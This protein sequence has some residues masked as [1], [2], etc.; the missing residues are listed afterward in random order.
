MSNIFER[1]D[2]V[3]KEVA[4][5]DT[6]SNNE[7]PSKREILK[8]IDGYASYIGNTVE[9][10]YFKPRNGDVGAALYINY[11]T[12]SER[13]K[14]GRKINAFYE[15]QDLVGFGRIFAKPDKERSNFTIWIN[16]TDSEEVIGTKRDL[17]EF[18]FTDPSFRTDVIERKPY[19]ALSPFE[20]ESGEIIEIKPGSYADFK[21]QGI[22]EARM[23]QRNEGR[24]W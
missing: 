5:K 4:S 17:I 3:S 15:D 24:K 11:E 2:M 20:P 8:G 9:Y 23:K 16:G 1:E 14:I 10:C 18:I 6:T 13:M 7:A 22:L 12:E 21:H 19:K